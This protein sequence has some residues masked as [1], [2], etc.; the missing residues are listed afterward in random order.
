MY[1]KPTLFFGGSFLFNQASTHSIAYWSAH[2]GSGPGVLGL[3]A[4]QVNWLLPLRTTEGRLCCWAAANPETRAT[5]HPKAELPTRARGSGIGSDQT[6]SLDFHGRA[7]KHEPRSGTANGWMTLRYLSRTLG[8]RHRCRSRT[9]HVL[10]SVRWS[11]T[12]PEFIEAA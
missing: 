6:V 10:R 5:E 8:R 4:M 7:W 12:V 1:M 11:E 3:S 9:L 2:I